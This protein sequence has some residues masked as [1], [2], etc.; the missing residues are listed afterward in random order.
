M[1]DVVDEQDNVL[2]VKPRDELT[3]EDITRAAILWVENQRGQV[4]TQQRSLSKPVNPGAW[5]SAVSGGVRAGET[6]ENAIVREAAEEI[7]FKGFTPEPVGKRLYVTEDGRIGPIYQ[8]FKAQCDMDADEF[9]LE[10]GEVHALAWVD[11]DELIRDYEK[12]PN[13]YVP[14]AAFWHEMFYAD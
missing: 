4:L 1:V 12:Q 3:R 6:Y 11:K 14:S 9:T 5:G 2:V 13:K 8:Y 7:G 10:D